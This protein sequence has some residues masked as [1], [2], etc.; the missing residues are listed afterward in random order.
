MRV[1]SFL[2]SFGQK[3]EIKSTSEIKN[4][5]K[6]PRKLV[7]SDRMWKSAKLEQAKRAT[8]IRQQNKGQNQLRKK[9]DWSETESEYRRKTNEC[10]FVE[11]STERTD[12]WSDCLFFPLFCPEKQHKK[13]KYMKISKKNKT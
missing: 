10:T 6:V 3:F 7:D 1:S 8:K 11:T 13:K 2:K 5:G 4:G 9:E 12:G